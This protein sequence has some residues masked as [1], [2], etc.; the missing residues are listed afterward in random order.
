MLIY[1]LTDIQLEFGFI[2]T[3]ILWFM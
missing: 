1:E 3:K 2:L